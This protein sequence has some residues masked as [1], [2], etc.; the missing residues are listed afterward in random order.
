MSEINKIIKYNEDKSYNPIGLMFLPFT[1]LGRFQTL[2][3]Q[4]NLANKL[5]MIK[6]GAVKICE[7]DRSGNQIIHD[8]KTEGQIFGE[9]ES[10]FR[11]NVNFKNSAIALSDNTEIYCLKLSD[12]DFDNIS[13]LTDSISGLLLEDLKTLK[14]RHQRLINYN[15]DYRIKEALLNLAHK[16]G[17]KFGDETL[18]KI[19]LTHDDIAKLA[20]TSRQTVTSVMNELKNK[21][22]IIY[23]RDRIQFRSL[24]NFLN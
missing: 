3:S 1:K 7:L 13:K 18:L 19:W 10:F 5:Y 17:Q 15:A 16:A 2:Y 11:P 23:S 20:D 21:N 14:L 9:W 6:S 4:G 24:S 22:K 8:I 12:L